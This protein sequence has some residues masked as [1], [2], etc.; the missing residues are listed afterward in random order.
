MPLFHGLHGRLALQCR[1]GQL[2][3]VQVHIT[4]QGLHQILARD[5]AVGLQ[6]IGNTAIEALHHAIGLGS[7]GLGQAVL[8]AQLFAQLVKHM[9]AAGLARSGCE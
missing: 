8:Y 9:V 4:R 6:Y 2:V 1:L 5:K 3:V 7:S